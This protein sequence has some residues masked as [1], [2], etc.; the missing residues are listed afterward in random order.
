M[1]GGTPPNDAYRAARARVAPSDPDRAAALTVECPTC[2][3]RP[4]QPCVSDITRQPL[5]ESPAHPDRIEKA[6]SKDADDR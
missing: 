1:S 6:H 2:L 4:H 5:T 3:A